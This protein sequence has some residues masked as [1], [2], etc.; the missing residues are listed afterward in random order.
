[1]TGKK[2][3]KDRVTLL[4]PREVVEAVDARVARGE[5]LNRSALAGELLHCALQHRSAREGKGDA[6][7]VLSTRYDG[8]AAAALQ[9]LL[10]AE[11]AARDA[12]GGVVEIALGDG[13]RLRVALV[14]GDLAALAGLSRACEAVR[15]V[16]R[17]QLT[18]SKVWETKR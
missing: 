5:G 11:E 6:V 7:G 14:R 8:G 15:G 4:L 3:E 2:E 9:G 1:M 17:V 13:E 18:L 16:R 12:V 10:S